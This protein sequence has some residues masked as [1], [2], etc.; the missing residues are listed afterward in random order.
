MVDMRQVNAAPPVVTAVSNYTWCATRRTQRV[1]S[2]VVGDGAVLKS[3]TKLYR[4][5]SADEPHLMV[6]NA[7]RM[8]NPGGQLPLADPT[9]KQGWCSSFCRGVV[10]QLQ[11][12]DVHAAVR[13]PGTTA[14]AVTA[15]VVII[16]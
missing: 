9:S 6:L 13:T 2:G 11:T 12:A 8:T 16:T 14:A 5:D 15:E 10:W 1:A 7:Q 3:N 4:V